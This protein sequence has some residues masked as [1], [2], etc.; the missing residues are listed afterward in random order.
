MDIRQFRIV[1]TYYSKFIFYLAYFFLS[2]FLTCTIAEVISV[3]SPG[4]VERQ[5]RN[6]VNIQ[7][8]VS[9]RG[10][11]ISS[12]GIP[13]QP[14]ISVPPSM[15]RPFVLRSICIT[16]STIYSQ[17]SLQAFFQP[18]LFKRISYQELEKINQKITLK[19]LKDGYVLTKAT[20]P[21][22]NLSS[23][24]V[25]IEIL[26]AY[27]VQVNVVGKTHGLEN[28]LDAYAKQLKKSRPLRLKVLQHYLLLLNRLPGVSATLK[29]S[30]D[31]VG[32]GAQA[33][34]FVIKQRRFVPNA[35]LNNNQ[36]P[37]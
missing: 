14:V 11:I 2:L 23:G 33:L 19:Y 12:A 34:T 8:E 4:Q 36:K 15:R 28:Y 37:F 3:F 9:A 29:K 26:E 24:Y 21:V 13:T 7:Q 17:A 1:K 22:Q 16:G 18:Y 35:L 20:L 25:H 6:T 5:L 30:P 32:S 27:V 31:L 10:P